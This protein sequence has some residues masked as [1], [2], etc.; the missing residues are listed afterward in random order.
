M[1]IKKDYAAEENLAAKDI[2][3]LGMAVS[4][5]YVHEQATPD[6]TLLVGP[7]VAVIGGTVVKYAGGNSPSFTAP[8]ANPRIDL[9]TLDASGTVARTAGTE[10][11][12]PV[13][14]DYPSDKLVICEVY[15]RVGQT[16]VRNVSVSGQGYVYRDARVLNSSPTTIYQRTLGQ[17]V[18]AGE[19][20]FLAG[21]EQG[22]DRVSFQTSNP[23][24]NGFTSAAESWF[25]SVYTTP[26]V[27]GFDKVRLK[28]LTLYVANSGGSAG[29]YIYVDVYAVDGSNKPT[30]AVLGTVSRN[31]GFPNGGEI[32]MRFSTPLELS[33]NTNYAFV[34]RDGITANTLRV[35]YSSSGGVASWSSS[36]S[37]AN[38]S[39]ASNFQYLKA[40]YTLGASG[41]LYKA[42]ADYRSTLNV[43][44]FAPTAGSSGAT[45]SVALDGVVG[46]SG[47][48][49]NSDY[50]LSDTP[51]AISTTGGTYKVKVGRALSATALMIQKALKV[52][53]NPSYDYT[54][55]DYIPFDGILV[56]QG[57]ITG[58]GTTTV[59]IL[60]EN[61][62]TVYTYED[63]A[64]QGSG[65]MTGSKGVISVPVRAGW[66]ASI[67]NYS[68]AKIFRLLV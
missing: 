46:G 2:N 28:S 10:G 6:L 3:S 8:S 14:P 32:T 23:S 30:G 25:A 34:I 66:R 47:L 62:S 61:D 21:V 55:E 41:K 64:D 60:D 35:Y 36:D 16:A 13:A 39:S 44:G 53:A 63:Y 12:S 38:W 9:L 26:N 24:Y 18:A 54:A 31:G 4:G 1:A 59:T 40:E 52:A 19:A 29:G 42:R 51:G 48:T 57:S 67:S 15:N 45:A 50:Y 11:A 68:S 65:T 58:D 33:A 20:V 22:A 17:D 37:G 7:G 56:V 5:L 49:A 27:S 43:L